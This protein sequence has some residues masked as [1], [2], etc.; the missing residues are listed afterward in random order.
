MTPLELAAHLLPAQL[1]LS[2]SQKTGPTCHRLKQIAVTSK[3]FDY[4]LALPM[5]LMFLYLSDLPP[6][7]NFF[8]VKASHFS[9]FPFDLVGETDCSSR[10]CIPELHFQQKNYSLL[11]DLRFPCL[12]LG[13]CTACSSGSLASSSNPPIRSWYHNPRIASATSFGG[14]SQ[15]HR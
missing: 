7:L 6:R 4:Q 9:L 3:L 12:P 15:M 8:S 14:P 11:F 5:D 1:S 10:L 2:D 13:F